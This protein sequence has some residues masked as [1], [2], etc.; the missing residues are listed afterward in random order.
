MNKTH[1]LSNAIGKHVPRY[2]P[3]G[4]MK[5]VSADKY[6]RVSTENLTF[7]DITAYIPTKDH[8]HASPQDVGKVS[9]REV[10]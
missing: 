8:T 4:N 2:V 3:A 9:S 10:L 1:A 6:D 5:A 7:N